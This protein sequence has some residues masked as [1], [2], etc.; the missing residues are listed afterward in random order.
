MNKGCEKC[1]HWEVARVPWKNI[2]GYAEPPEDGFWWGVC[3]SVHERDVRVVRAVVRSVGAGN[4][5]SV[6]HLVTRSDFSCNEFQ[7]LAGGESK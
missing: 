7:D 4:A 2:P 6:A 3:Q 1:R 5:A